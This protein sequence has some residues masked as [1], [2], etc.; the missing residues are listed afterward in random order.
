VRAHGPGLTRDA[1]HRDWTQGS[2]LGN[3]LS[4]SWPMLIGSSLNMLGP[5]IDMIWIGRLG[6]ASIAG[7]GVSAIAIMLVNSLMGGLF[8]GTSAMVARFMG[9]RDETSANRVA[10]QAF[11]VG[12]AYCIVLA[13]IGIFL[14]DKILMSL[15]VAADVVAEGAAYMRIQLVG[16]VTMGAVTAGQS[17]MNASGDTRTPMKISVSFRLLHMALAPCL[18]LG[19]WEFPK[20]GVQGAALSN[21]VSQ[22]VGGGLA[23]WV[24]FSGRTRL[25]VTLKRFRFDRDIIWRTVKI[26]FPAS[27][28]QV[29]RTFSELVL[30]RFI[31][32]FGT[33]AVAAHSVA[34]RI[35]MFM[36]MFCG[37]IGS[38]SG[39]LAGQALGAKQ[40]Q[41]A[42]RTGWLAAGLATGFTVLCAVAIW[43]WAE[44]LIGIFSS[45]G[46]LVDIASTFLRIQITGYV[47]WGMVVALSMCL[48]GVGD[49]VVPM[50]TNLA[51]MWGFSLTLAYILSQHTSLGVYGIRWA[52]VVGIVLR[53]VIYGVYFKAGRWQ[54]KQV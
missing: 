32:P 38:S 29:E 30:V 27:I 11:V 4:L 3:L 12:L 34:Q 25:R 6:A 13:V 23:M 5:T 2:I 15:G 28:T 20:L 31:V 51:T 26:G 35:D 52:M 33:F 39:V 36:Q 46:Q 14:A 24:L 9:A 40:P 50:I 41:R 45:E 54:R 18:I 10:Q 8:A 42:S 22:A 53:A 43:F 19:L 48:N 37:S 7:V 47:F 16:I 1:V 49:T 21:V 44:H 17:I